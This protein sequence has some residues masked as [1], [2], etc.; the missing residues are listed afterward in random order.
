MLHA[1]WKEIVAS[2]VVD[3][4]AAL[5][6]WPDACGPVRLSFSSGNL[7]L[8][9]LLLPFCARIRCDVS[10]VCACSAYTFMQRSM[11][12]TRTKEGVRVQV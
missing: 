6:C 4:S 2:D 9:A 1:E 3:M 12:G 5:Q 11:I 7:G 8:A 10:C